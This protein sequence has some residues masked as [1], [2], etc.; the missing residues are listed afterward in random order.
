MGAINKW[1]YNNIISDCMWKTPTL[2]AGKIVYRRHAEFP[3]WSVS[4]P[5][6]KMH[7]RDGTCGVLLYDVNN[8]SSWWSSRQARFSCCF[9]AVVAC[10]A[11]TKKWTVKVTCYGGRD[12]GKMSQ[13]FFS[14]ST[15]HLACVIQRERCGML[16][17][18]SWN[19]EIENKIFSYSFFIDSQKENFRLN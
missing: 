18:R 9:L 12:S 14:L 15:H 4:F 11:S 7:S 13:S 8:Y 5:N 10:L 1:K 2:P 17:C 3:E 6:K 19:N 16:L